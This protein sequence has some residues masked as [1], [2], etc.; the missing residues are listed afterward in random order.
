MARARRCSYPLSRIN[1]KEQKYSDFEDWKLAVRTLQL[2]TYAVRSLI[3]IL[4]LP[5]LLGFPAVAL[6]DVPR[7]QLIQVTEHT[8]EFL[9]WQRCNKL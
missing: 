9:V 7:K 4:T 6:P 3:P 2:R 8:P 1:T 5:Y